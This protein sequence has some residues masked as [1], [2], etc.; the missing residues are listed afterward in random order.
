ML[1]AVA[2]SCDAERKACC[3]KAGLEATLRALRA[4]IGREEI[5]L[6]QGWRAQRRRLC[7]GE[8]C[9]IIVL[10]YGIIRPTSRPRPALKVV[11]RRR[12]DPNPVCP[13]RALEMPAAAWAIKSR[14]HPVHAP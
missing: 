11:E 6:L 8:G 13:Y 7:L 12:P 10:A 4:N 3:E 5:R 9:E 1:S 2:A 14:R